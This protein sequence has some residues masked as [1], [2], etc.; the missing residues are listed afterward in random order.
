M[1]INTTIRDLKPSRRKARVRDDADAHLVPGSEVKLPHERDESPHA[2]NTSNPVTR[3]AHR[4]ASGGQQDT[5]LRGGAVDSF[6][7]STGT[8]AKTGTRVRGTRPPRK[9]GS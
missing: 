6:R 1:P 2:R 8:R 9:P 5:D 7:R 4:D 3:Q